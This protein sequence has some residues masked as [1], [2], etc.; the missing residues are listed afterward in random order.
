LGAAAEEQ[1]M[2]KP[3]FDPETGHLQ[4]DLY[5]LERP[6]Y[7]KI[8]SEGV[9]TQKELSEHA[10]HVAELLRKLETQLSPESRELMN[11][12]LCELAIL[13]ALQTKMRSQTAFR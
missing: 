7:Q 6:S 13:H 11:E 1:F 3:W 8:M 10:T 2:T 4:L 5:V 12:V 9:V